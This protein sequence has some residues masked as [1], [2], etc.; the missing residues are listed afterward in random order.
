MKERKRGKNKGKN[1]VGLKEERKE[2]KI[3]SMQSRD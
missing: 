1:K 3:R 2:R